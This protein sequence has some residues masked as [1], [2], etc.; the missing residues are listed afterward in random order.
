MCFSVRQ[1]RLSTGPDH[2][3]N[4]QELAFA[5]LRARKLL[6]SFQKSRARCLAACPAIRDHKARAKALNFLALNLGQF[7]LRADELLLTVADVHGDGFTNRVKGIDA[8]VDVFFGRIMQIDQCAGAAVDFLA[9]MRRLHRAGQR[10][11]WTIKAIEHSNF[12]GERLDL[13][14]REYERLWRAMGL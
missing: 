2:R 14:K 3:Q 8:P 9:E 13:C 1:I 7:R 5:L 11:M 4:M 12:A 6:E 10:F